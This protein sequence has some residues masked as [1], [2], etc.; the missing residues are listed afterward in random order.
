M[1]GVH[2]SLGPAGLLVVC[3][4]VKQQH[5]CN[6]YGYNSDVLVDRLTSQT[7]PMVLEMFDGIF[8]VS[9]RKRK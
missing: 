3:N 6:Q 2:E 7:G 5:Y 9:I 4:T 1:I 8:T